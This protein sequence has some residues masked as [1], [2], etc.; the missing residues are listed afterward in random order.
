MWQRFWDVRK[1]W[2]KILPKLLGSTKPLMGHSVLENL[3]F[4]CAG[5]GNITTNIK[6]EEAMGA[7]E[8]KK[9]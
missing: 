9:T 3:L 7:E 1:P 8:E 5:L 4:L 2:S 6:K